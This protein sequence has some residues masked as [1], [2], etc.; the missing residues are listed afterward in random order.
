[1]EPAS[2]PPGRVVLF[3]IGRDSRSRP[4]GTLGRRL[5]AAHDDVMCVYSGVTGESSGDGLEVERHVSEPDTGTGSIVDLLDK[6]RPDV[7]VRSGSLPSVTVLVELNERS[8]PLVLLDAHRIDRHPLPRWIGTKGRRW[9]LSGL[10]Q[11]L[12]VT[13]SDSEALAQMGAHYSKVERSGLLEEHGGGVLPCNEQERASLAEL[14]AARPV[15]CAACVTAAEMTAV[16]EAH[17]MASRLS[18]RLLLILVPED[19]SQGAEIHQRFLESDWR[20][21]LRSDGAEPDPDVQIYVADA[22]GEMGLWFRIAPITFLGQSLLPPGGAY[23]PFRPAALGSAVVHGPH[24]AGREAAFHRL[25]EAGAAR[26]VFTGA[27]LGAVVG[28]LLS[29]DAAALMAHRAWEVV[30]EGTA[31]IE[32]AEDIILGVLDRARGDHAAA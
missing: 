9:L 25:A 2:R 3:I 30:S 27:E 20:S 17:R 7:V 11:A 24:V 28:D 26:R 32:R 14:L 10:E 15:W 29:P 18:H 13:K 4:I 12:V 31:V 6:W 23:D 22:E 16:L 5:C 21:A 8:I 19:L 1:M